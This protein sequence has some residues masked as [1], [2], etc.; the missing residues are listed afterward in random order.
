MKTAAL[1]KNVLALLLAGLVPAVIAS[2]HSNPLPGEIQK[3]RNMSNEQIDR[4]FMG[5]A[6]EEALKKKRDEEKKGAAKHSSTGSVNTAV[7]NTPRQVLPHTGG[8]TVGSGAAIQAPA[9]RKRGH[10]AM[11]QAKSIEIDWIACT[12]GM[13]TAQTNYGLLKKGSVIGQSGEKV[14]E[15]G[16]DYIQTNKQKIVW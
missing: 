10:V 9:D 7:I 2:D 15:I 5:M 1:K 6:D 16:T 4:I 8:F 12:K 14:Q 11:A 13:C 3:D